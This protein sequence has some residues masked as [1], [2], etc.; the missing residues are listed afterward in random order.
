MGAG[1]IDS[2]AVHPLESMVAALEADLAG[3]V[4]ATAWTLTSNQ[5]ADLL[6]RLAIVERKLAA[7]KLSMLREADRHQVGDPNGY[8]NT[9]GWWSAVTRSTKPEARREL[10][11]AERLDQDEHEPVRAAALNGAVSVDQAA[12]IIKAVEDLP[13]D[14][15]DAGLRA[16]AENHLIEFAAELDPTQLRIAGRR[17]LDVEAP[18]IAEQALARVLEAEEAHAEQ[19]ASFTMR[20]DGHGS[21]VGR[22]KIPLLAG[23]MLEKHLAAIASPRHQNAGPDPKPWRWGTAFTEYIETR[24]THGT[25]KTGGI[26]ATVVV[27]MTLESLLG[28]LA[29]AS[30]LDTGEAI[31][32]AQARRLACEAGIIPAVLGGRSEVLDLGRQR[33]FHSKAQRIALAL[34]HGGCVVEG[35]DWPP[36]MCHAHHDQ[37]WSEGGDTSVTNGRLLCPRHHARAHDPTYT[38]TKLPEGKIRFHRR[39]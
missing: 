7:A 32:A 15:T 3:G 5:L 24:P 10:K 23:R 4:D 14:L 37:P 27:T 19:T 22:F 9:V 39:N 12:V 36:G 25:P 35:C 16:K 13:T 33:R 18:E 30:L 26:A 1:H 2:G 29:A 20:P 38:M 28:G 6:P 21:M 8:S 34:K 31:S 11:L 17:I